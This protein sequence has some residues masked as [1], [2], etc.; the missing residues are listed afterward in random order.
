M[1]ISIRKLT[2][3]LAE[4]YVRFF[5]I[6]PHDDDIDDNKCYCVCW[7]GDDSEGRDFSSREKRRAIAYKYV[8]EGALQGYLAYHGDKTVGWCNANTKS[9]CLKCLSWRRFMDGVPAEE[10]DAKI[11][12][13]SVFCFTIAP[14]MKRQ[15]IATRL[16]ERVCRDAATDGFGFVEAYPAKN[17]IDE[18]NFSGHIEMYEKCGFTVYREMVE[19]LVVRK[20]C[21]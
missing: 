6:T 15:G 12:I 9:E 21:T 5:D 2:P 14:E 17:Y 8:R 18:T 16:L 4:D 1:D 19:R 10:S 7:C 13:K 20:R 3:E 11:K